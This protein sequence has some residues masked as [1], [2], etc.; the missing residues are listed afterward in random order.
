MELTLNLLGQINAKASSSSPVK[1]KYIVSVRAEDLASWLQYERRG[2]RKS[3][4]FRV[5]QN[6][7]IRIDRNI[8][9]GTDDDGYLLQQPVKISEIARILLGDK[10]VGVPRI[11]LGSL[12]WNVRQTNVFDIVQ[13]QS[14]G[15]PPRY[16]LIL[17]ADAIYLTDSA[18]RHFGIVEA[19]RQ[20]KA[21]PE[22]YPTFDPMMEFSVEI[23]NLDAVGER[24]LFAELNS[25][26]KKISAA[27]QKQMDVSSPIGALKD[28]VVAADQASRKLLENNIEVS[29][30]QNSKHTLMTMSVFVASIGEMF[31]AVN[32]KKARDDEDL[33]SEFADYYCDFIY[34]L[35]DGLTVVFP[36]PDGT[37]K[38]VK[39]FENLYNTIIRPVEDRFE[40]EPEAQYEHLLDKARN[41]AAALNEKLRSIDISN[42]NS[43]IKALFRIGGLI[44]LM[45][46]WKQVIDRIHT[47]LNVP[48]GGQ[49]FQKE[50]AE[51]FEV[52][53][54]GVSIATLNRDETINVQVQTKTIDT[55]YSYLIEKLDL[56][57]EPELHVKELPVSAPISSNAPTYNWKISE[58]DKTYKTVEFRFAQPK[59]VLPTEDQFKL[60]VISVGNQWA[61]KDLKGARHLMPST[62]LDD[63]SFS[64]PRYDGL[65]GYVAVFEVP[66][67]PAKINNTIPMKIIITYPEI[68]GEPRKFEA[69]FEVVN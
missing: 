6:S 58:N 50:N 12:T 31:S 62:I 13:Q 55:I 28:A 38:K 35:H 46:E 2:S 57:F 3:D 22:K 8:Q 59:G 47:G 52:R 61:E 24:E 34:A 18:H 49:F 45:P 7:L 23:Y 32:I 27:K 10:S 54:S 37:S 11:Y 51:L 29:S 1:P 53:S 43:T 42:H 30:N 56:D 20:W 44:R 19:F 26:Q 48:M 66:L 15:K 5:A 25:K 21:N 17:S 33:R 64:H 36:L 40:E 69:A 65:A 9:R 39:P 68:D 4:P 63:K 16:K 41:E 60:S 67:P 14:E